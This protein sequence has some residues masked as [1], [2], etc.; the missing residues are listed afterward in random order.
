[1]TTIYRDIS[2]LLLTLLLV[3]VNIGA[4]YSQEVSIDDYSTNSKNQ[5]QLEIESDLDH[6]YVLKIRTDTDS[7]FNFSSSISMGVSVDQ[8]ISEPLGSYPLEHYQ[9]LEYPI[10]SP[11]DSDGDGIDDITEYQDIPNQ[12]PLN[13]APTIDLTDG[14]VM[15]DEFSTFQSMS[16]EKDFVQW[17]EFLNGKEFV[18]FII[19]DFNTSPKLYFIN[20]NKYAFHNDFAMAMGIDYI[21]DHVQ[22]GNIMYHPTTIS[23]NGTVGTF[24]FNFSNG[25]P[26]EFEITQKTQEIVAANMPFLKNNFS[27]YI[28]N[29]NKSQYYLDSALY[30]KS[31]VPILYESDVYKDFDYWGLNEGEGF[32]FFRR[33]GLDETPGLKDIVLYESLPNNLPR[34]AGIM[35]SVIQTPLSHVNLRAIQGNI[36]NAFVRDPLDVSKIVDLLDDYVYYKVENDHYY[37]RKATIEEVNDWFEELR[38]DGDQSPP[39]NLDYQDIL[40][41]DD[42]EFSMYDAFGA[43]CANVATMRSFGF[44]GNTIPNGYGIPF[45]YYQEFM[46][47]NNF[48]EELKEIIDYPG[49]T[50]DREIRKALLKD[51]REKIESAEMPSKMLEDLAT[52]QASFPFGTSIRCR[53]S[54]NNE[55]LE[56]F[57]GAGLY[58]SK[59]QH[60]YEGHISKS[61]KQVFA[62]LWNLRAYEEREFYRINHFETSMAILCHPNYANEIANGVGVS[63]DPI[64]STQSTY[65]LNTQLGEDL[66]TNPENEST[67]EEILVNSTVSED[68][69]YTVIE[70]SSL[71]PADELVLSEEHI[72]Q[73]RDYLTIIHNEFKA[74]YEAEGNNS[75]AMD[76]EYKITSDST[77][78]I[79]QARPWVTYL[80]FEEPELIT[81]NLELTVYPNPSDNLITIQCT[82]CDLSKVKITNIIGQV[83]YEK[84]LL[85]N[86]ESKLETTVQG[87]AAGTYFVNAYNAE[88]ELYDSQK[89]IVSSRKQ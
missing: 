26:R 88:N 9:V 46:K 2:S 87:L 27:Y 64:Y 10:N 67:P 7:S 85:N 65:Y 61:V 62:S 22:K 60:P 63:T 17:S 28:T 43:K 75:F 84:E 86:D 23:N 54:S 32:G 71:V 50:T 52:M 25:Q 14:I 34:V 49:F 47:Y 58:D 35:T 44:P 19:V 31:R 30:N 5:V 76:I 33:V 48:F 16:V 12:S 13:A 51:F 1:M 36:P 83:L 73:L 37:I 39:L 11:A 24:A 56:G 55:D 70:H 57:N 68:D 78:S 82:N 42:I 38:P 79:K 66:I 15:V 80:N 20:S 4:L 69:F 29:T 18:K 59:T 6:Y 41:L 21:G 53:S 77:L 72:A 8:I 3:V 45:Y 81:P 89:I 40:P 74:L